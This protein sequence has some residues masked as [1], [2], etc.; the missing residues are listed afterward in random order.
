MQDAETFYFELECRLTVR[1]QEQN[2]NHRKISLRCEIEHLSSMQLYIVANK[3]KNLYL[4]LQQVLF[5]FEVIHKTL[6]LF[7]C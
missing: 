6:R 4:L 5:Y 2:V 7:D 1:G 3:P